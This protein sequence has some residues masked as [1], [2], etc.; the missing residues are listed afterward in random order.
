MQ[1]AAEV[2][3]FKPSGEETAW[4]GGQLAD[5]SM[6]VSGWV[7]T[8]KKMQ[9]GHCIVRGDRIKN[10]GVFGAAPA[11]MVKVSSFESRH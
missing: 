9:K 10:N 4:V 1:Q 8:I 3:Y 6:D 2:L 7:S 5:G 11:T